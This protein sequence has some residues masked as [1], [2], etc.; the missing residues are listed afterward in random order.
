MRKLGLGGYRFSLAWPRVQPNGSGLVNERGLDFYRRLVARLHEGGIEPLVTLY[1]WDLPQPLEDAGGWANRDTA[2]RFAEF[3]AIVGAALG[4][5]V[6]LW[7]T[8]NEP[9]FAAFSGY[10]LGRLAPGRQET[11]AGVL[12]AHNLLL[13]HGKGC[14]RCR[15]RPCAGAGRYHAQ[16]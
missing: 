8:L 13:A 2:E 3:A 14:R 5:G 11:R 16:P 7:V 12:A 4:D 1:H 10:E 15:R 9:F 6:D